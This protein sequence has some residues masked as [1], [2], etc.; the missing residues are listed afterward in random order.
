MAF[1]EMNLFEPL[2]RNTFDR[3]FDK[4]NGVSSE[5][6]IDLIDKKKIYGTF[7]KEFRQS[8]IKLDELKEVLDQDTSELHSSNVIKSI[9]GLLRKKNNAKIPGIK[10][11]VHFRRLD[12]LFEHWPDAKVIFLTRNPKAIV[13]SKLNDKATQERKGKS[14][15]HKFL[16]HYFTVL[17][18]S[19]EY[20]FSIRTYFRYASNL[21]LMT[22][23]QLVLNTDETIKGLCRWCNLEFEDTM[24]EV[25]GKSSSHNSISKKGL[26]TQSIDKYKSVLN[27]FDSFLISLLTYRYY[28]KIKNE[29]GSNF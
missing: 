18:F 27:S 21:K 8:G 29:L 26:H 6:I 15:L 7:W 25:T 16:V 2:R 24:L 28:T 13:A 10:Y 17:Y 19:I 12:Y 14:F 5:E 22:Y 1:D 4:S 9:L 11:P 23:D 3:F 20:I